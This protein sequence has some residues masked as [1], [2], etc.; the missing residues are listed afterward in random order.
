MR[1]TILILI[2]TLLLP[3]PILAVDGNLAPVSLQTEEC[4]GCHIIATPGIVKDWQSSRHSRTIPAQALKK[5]KLAKIS[6]QDH[7]LMLEFIQKRDAERVEIL[8][9]EHI[10]RGQAAVLKEFDNNTLVA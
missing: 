8:V 2:L 5:E 1:N 7:R 3:V 4:I 9:R 10:L 6:N